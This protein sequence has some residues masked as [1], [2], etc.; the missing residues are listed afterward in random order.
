V[1]H[2][3]DRTCLDTFE[4]SDKPVFITH[5]GARAVWPT[6]RM[7]PDD[8]LR[9]CAAGGGVIGIEAAPHTTLSAAHPEHSIDSV[10]DHF[11]YCAELL[12]IEHVAFGPDTFFGDHVGFHGVFAKQLGMNAWSA[13]PHPRVGYVAGMEN[14][15]ENFRNIVGWLVRKGYSDADITA[16][17]G[18]NILRVL[19]EVW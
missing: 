10:M 5:A 8:V 11:E 17:I 15:A 18:G 3:G 16:V 7:K 4:V 13:P 9:A 19:R 14:P 2:S 1:S 6:P 12:G